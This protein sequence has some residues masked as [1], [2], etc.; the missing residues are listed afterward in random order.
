MRQLFTIALLVCSMLVVAQEQK[1][2]PQP[3]QIVENKEL[4]QYFV[5]FKSDSTYSDWFLLVQPQW[6]KSENYTVT[7]SN[8]LGAVRNPGVMTLKI[9]DYG[10]KEGLG[11]YLQ[12]YHKIGPEVQHH[13]DT[14]WLNRP[15]SD[16][17]RLYYEIQ[18]NG[19]K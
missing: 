12:P 5:R 18:Q 14:V 2:E 13:V 10:E 19:K 17:E 1:Q 16:Q 11:Y 8:E 3:F 9:P 15:L 4:K 6:E 7:E